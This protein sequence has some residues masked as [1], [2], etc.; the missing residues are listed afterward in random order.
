MK[1]YRFLSWHTFFLLAL[2]ALSVQ[3]CFGTG[4]SSS[5]QNF[6]QVNTST[7]SHI[8]INSGNQALFKG[9]IYFTQN[10][11]LFVVDGNRNITQLTKNADV[12]DPSISPDG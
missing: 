8:G 10:R 7:G 1:R 11:N 3:G 9:K 5:N 12:R 6:K 2:V 4:G